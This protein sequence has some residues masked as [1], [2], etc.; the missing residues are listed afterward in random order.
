MKPII[1]VT[2]D[3]DETGSQFT[4]LAYIEAVQ[5][6]GGVPIILP[7]GN[8]QDVEQICRM[9]NGLL[10]T[11][12]GDVDPSYFN[13][14]PDPKLGD[15][16]PERD[17]IELL[18]VSHML[19][20]DKPILGICRGMQ[21]LNIHFGGTVYQD[22]DSQYGDTLIKH[23]QKARS[24][25]PT[26]SVTVK[27]QTKYHLIVN[28]DHIRVNSFHHQALKGIG[29]PLI[30]SGESPDGVAEAVESTEHAFVLGLQWHP[31]LLLKRQDANSAKLFAAFIDACR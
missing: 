4:R 15:V 25:F 11:G 14:D 19:K 7:T 10:L 6:A 9:L 20:A 2:T 13:E 3:V 1:G 28:E 27:P 29:G 8:D 26:H 23:S 16:T 31:E 12:G 21:L 17:S 22:L 5:K 30:V 24:E 18:L